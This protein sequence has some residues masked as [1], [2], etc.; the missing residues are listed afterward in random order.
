MIDN[1][2]IAAVYKDNYHRAEVRK[3]RHRADMAG[4]VYVPITYYHYH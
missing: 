1:A 3:T 2:W 4:R